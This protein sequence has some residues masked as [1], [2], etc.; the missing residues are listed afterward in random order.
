MLPRISSAT[1]P[2]PGAE[3]HGASE[4]SGVHSFVQAT[5]RRGRPFSAFATARGFLS[6]TRSSARAGPSGVRRPC[7]QLRS[8]ATLTPIIVANCSCD[9]P[10]GIIIFMYHNDHEPPHFHARY[11]SAEA[12]IAIDSLSVLKG[13]L[14]PRVLGLVLEWAVQHESELRENW[15]LARQQVPLRS[16]EPLK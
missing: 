14:P 10:F 15:T 7:S 2:S 6:V 5:P 1:A 13:R 9:W 8:V 12:L 11:G 3:D 4:R 16:I